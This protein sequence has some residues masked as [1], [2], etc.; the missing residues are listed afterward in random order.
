MDPSESFRSLKE[1][2]DE[3]KKGFEPILRRR[4]PRVAVPGTSTFTPAHEPAPTHFNPQK[5]Y[6]PLLHLSF[7]SGFQFRSPVTPVSI[8]AHLVSRHSK[9]SFPHSSPI[10]TSTSMLDDDPSEPSELPHLSPDYADVELNGLNPDHI[11]FRRH[12][13]TESYTKIHNL[14]TELRKDRIS[15]IDI[16]IQV[17][18]SDDMQYDRY[19]GN[20]YRE[21]NTKIAIL[22]E[23]IMADCNDR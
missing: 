5:P 22:L 11:H 18:D 7:A 9:E 20:L 1:Q 19:G 2:A 17:V 13:T 16:L 12:R 6:P 3:L 10:T 14:L 15:P 21:D 8:H 4:K 23:K